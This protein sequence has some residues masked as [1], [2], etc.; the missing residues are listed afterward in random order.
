MSLQRQHFLLSYLKT[1]SVGAA[2]TWTSGLPLGRLEIPLGISTL[3]SLGQDIDNG[4]TSGVNLALVFSC[5]HNFFVHTGSCM[6]AE[7]K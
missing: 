1:L 6:K 2:G 5:F 3:P 4:I 7:E